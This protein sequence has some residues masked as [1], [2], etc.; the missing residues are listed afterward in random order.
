MLKFAFTKNDAKSMFLFF[1]AFY[2][3]Q[4]RFSS[5]NTPRNYIDSVQAISPL[6]IF[7]LGKTSEILPFLLGLRK[8]EYLFFFTLRES[9]LEMNHSLI[10]CNSSFT[11]TKA[12]LYPYLSRTNLCS[13]QT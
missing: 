9:L 6:F 5:N 13:Q 3:F 12:V 1:D 8:N 10:F 7:N 2:V 11:L 4:L